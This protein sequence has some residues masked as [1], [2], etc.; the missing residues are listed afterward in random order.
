MQILLI[1]NPAMKSD[2]QGNYRQNNFDFSQGGNEAFSGLLLFPCLTISQPDYGALLVFMNRS[3]I[4]GRSYIS[5]KRFT[6]YSE[7]GERASAQLLCSR[8]KGSNM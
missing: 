2:V 7:T 4:E 3:C 6:G 1:L 5:R 8:E